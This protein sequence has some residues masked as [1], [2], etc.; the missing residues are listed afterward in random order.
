[1][2]ERWTEQGPSAPLDDLLDEVVLS[3]TGM[4]VRAMEQVLALG[5]EVVPAIA[6]AI[7]FWEGDAEADTL[8]LIVLLGEMR[9]PLAVPA[10]VGQL[11][12]TEADVLAH[13]SAEGLAKIGAAA[14]P[15]LRDVVSS[16][17]AD[18]RLCAYAALGWIDAE[19]A[20]RVL[21]DALKR[22]RELADVLGMALTQHAGRASVEGLFSAYQAVEPWQRPAIED[23]IR[24]AHH[25]TP[26][27]V[28]WRSDWRLRYRRRPEQYGAFHP[29]WPS[30]VAVLRQD[31][32]VRANRD[33]PLRSLDEILAAPQDEI[34][35][36]PELCD[37]CGQPIERPMAV[38]MCPSTAV[39]VAL[40]QMAVL[41]GA[42]ED[43]ID[44]I[45]ELLDDLEEQE[46][47]VRDEP[48]PKKARA[49]EEREDT[50]ADFAEARATCEWLI[51]QGV[52]DVARGKAMI[53]AHLAELAA[54]HG[55][56][57]G[58]LAPVAPVRTRAE[59]I[60][61]NDPCPCGSGQKYK[62]CCLDRDASATP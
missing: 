11:R 57:D 50:L 52:E 20:Y 56:P 13:A 55:D 9:S 21:A 24:A 5:E 53:A 36:D 48:E 43:G 16:G 38:P 6:E 44:D 29:E 59:K 62:R 54:R 8:W 31:E 46:F 41:S 34:G 14:V 27:D 19:E 23:A 28:S 10:L 26:P 49:R 58:L 39:A 3:P 2:T 42:L 33:V 37:D 30:I 1:M 25:R 7:E 35:P 45:F 40:D 22:D 47:A 18:Q 15:A 32:G 12:A 60:G 51:E 61:R 17:D 4:P